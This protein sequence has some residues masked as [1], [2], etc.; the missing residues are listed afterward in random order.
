MQSHD[1]YHYVEDCRSRKVKL[2]DFYEFNFIFAMD[3]SN[4]GN[5]KELCPTDSTS[6]LLML[7]SYDNDPSSNGVIDDPYGSPN[8]DEYERVYDQCSRACC[9]FMD[10]LR[11]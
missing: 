1:I 6:K 3:S 2:Q 4:M 9:R 10:S 7:G 11:P 8:P 5:L